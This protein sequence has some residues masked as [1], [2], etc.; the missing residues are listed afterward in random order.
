MLQRRLVKHKHNLVLGAM[1][2]IAY[3]D[4]EIRL[5]KGD[6]LFIYTDGVT[7]ATNPDYKLFG[8]DRTL[9]ALNR[10]RE[11][12]P[13]EI[14]EGVDVSIKEFVG[15]GKQFDDLTMLCIEIR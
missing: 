2:D 1:P 9:E 8:I 5:G 4:H 3:T 10:Y 11:G 7:E 13:Q 15:D 6:K 14:L 12:S